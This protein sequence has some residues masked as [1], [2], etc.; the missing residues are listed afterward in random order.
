MKPLKPSGVNY[1]I[2]GVTLLL[3]ANVVLDES[4]ERRI[5]EPTEL[6]T[7]VEM[8]LGVCEKRAVIKYANPA[9]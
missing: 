5:H 8:E 7:G 9:K 4:M 3:L 6:A 1:P 2:T